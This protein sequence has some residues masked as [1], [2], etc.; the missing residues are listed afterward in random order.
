MQ[1]VVYTVVFVF[2]DP[3]VTF[4]QTMVM[5]SNVVVI[6]RSHMKCGTY[7]FDEFEAAAVG[8]SK[9]CS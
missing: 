8:G 5:T 1:S 6:F 2:T 7:V 3:V 4:Q 9:M